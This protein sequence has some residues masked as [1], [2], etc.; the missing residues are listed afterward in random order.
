LLVEKEDGSHVWSAGITSRVAGYTALARKRQREALADLVKSA[1][2]ARDPALARRLLDRAVAL[3]LEGKTADSLE[4]KVEKLAAKPGKKKEALSA[5]VAV[6]ATA[7]EA[8]IGNLIFDRAVR[9][10]QNGALGVFLLREA[11]RAHPENRPALALLE[12]RAPKEF[13]LGDNRAWLDWHL[14]I[15]SPG[16]L[17]AKGDELELKRARHHW[18]PDLYGVRSDEILLITAMKDFEL[19]ARCAAHADSTCRALSHLFETSEP[20]RRDAGPLTVF[21]YVDKKAYKKHAG[22][23]RSIDNPEFL[24]WSTG[25][26]SE[27]DD[28]TR[29][30]WPQDVDAERRFLTVLRREIAQHW[31]HARN[32]RYSVSQASAAWRQPGYWIQ[33]GFINLIAQ[34]RYDPRA[35]RWELFNP[36]CRNLDAL[37]AA[38]AQQPGRI[39]PWK[40]LFLLTGREARKLPDKNDIK[41]VRR[42]SLSRWNYS[43][44]HIY[45]A[46]AGAACQFL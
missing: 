32:P 3:G 10:M 39:H 18:R 2:K 37:Q 45:L 40:S 27:S 36:R 4:I 13:A 46:Q 35:G 24:E 14:E 28:I 25:H 30:H 17:A 11:L 20:V 44:Y 22:D 34:G 29:I 19:V 16:F 31:M 41:L 38:I 8:I 12:K 42:W 33:K 6:Q 23:Y 15:E 43:A 1:L 5:Q 9:E 7:A 26:W 21:L